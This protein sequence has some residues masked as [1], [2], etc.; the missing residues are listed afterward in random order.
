MPEATVLEIRGRRIGDC[1]FGDVQ[2]R[3]LIAS[4]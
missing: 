2:D 4:L 1:V 3:R